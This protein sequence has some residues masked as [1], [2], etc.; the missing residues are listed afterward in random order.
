MA[1]VGKEPALVDTKVDP[2]HS[3]P[4]FNELELRLE[5]RVNPRISRCLRR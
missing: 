5:C 1:L 4:G 3:V 2:F